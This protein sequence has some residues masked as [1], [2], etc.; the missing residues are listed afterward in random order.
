MEVFVATWNVGNTMVEPHE[1]DEWLRGA[2]RDA[3]VVVIALQ[4]AHYI[5]DEGRERI[6]ARAAATSVVAG[7]WLCCAGCLMA[8]PLLWDRRKKRRERKKRERMERELALNP[9]LKASQRKALVCVDVVTRLVDCLENRG[10]AYAEGASCKWGQMR[11]LI[12]HKEALVSLE[13][14]ATAVARTG[15]KVTNNDMHTGVLGN[16][17]GLISSF[18][19]APARARGAGDHIEAVLLHGAGA[20]MKR[21][22]ITAVGVHLPAHEGDQF[23]ADRREAL[24]TILQKARD[25]AAMDDADL[26]VLTGDMNF[27]LTGDLESKSVADDV[28]NGDYAK[29]YAADELARDHSAADSVVAGWELPRCDFPPTFKVKRGVVEETYNRKRVP[30]WC[31]RVLYRTALESHLI[32]Y[33][34]HPKLTTSDHKPVAL[35][36]DLLGE[37]RPGGGPQRRPSNGSSAPSSRRSSLDPDDAVT[38]D[39]DIRVFERARR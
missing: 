5:T 35:A 13:P 3:S 33:A 15:G 6:E 1:I 17:G 32:S 21:R 7:S 11:L 12:F 39:L 26:A 14:L 16:K 18:A 23:L 30:A 4:E 38:S 24:A 19:V 22:R 10:F 20:A 29:H 25:D 27:R 28:K 8:V 31:D 9:A 34:S 2:T 37:A 36:L